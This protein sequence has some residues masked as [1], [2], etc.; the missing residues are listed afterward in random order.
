MA[1]KISATR[2][3]AVNLSWAVNQLKELC[4]NF[5]EMLVILK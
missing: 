1:D 4:S 5:L 2:P 3:T